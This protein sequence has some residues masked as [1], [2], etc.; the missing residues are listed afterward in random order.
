VSNE[1]MPHPHDRRSRFDHFAERAARATS[2]APFFLLCLVFVVAWLPSLWIVS[3]EA[4]QFFVQTVTAIVTFLLVALLQNAQKRNEE[5]INL[6]L[7]A[8]AEGIADLMRARTGDDND[9]RDNIEK[10]ADTVGLEHRVT[11][12]RGDQGRRGRR[13]ANGS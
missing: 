13:S 11:T 5:A 12:V 7:N 2:G 9:L 4:S 6:K 8:I 3:V 10:L 1:H